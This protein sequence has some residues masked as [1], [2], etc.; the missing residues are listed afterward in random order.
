ML[1]PPPPQVCIGGSGLSPPPTPPSPLVSPL[2]PS[3]KCVNGTCDRCGFHNIPACPHLAPILA[4]A[5]AAWKQ[6]DTATNGAGCSRLM[7]V[8]KGHR[9]RSDLI[10]RT[11]ALLRKYWG[12]SDLLGGRLDTLSLY[13]VRLSLG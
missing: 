12:H 6:W 11:E 5:D 4:T 3:P 8:I 13:R 2:R 7:P 10:D 1:S 9:L